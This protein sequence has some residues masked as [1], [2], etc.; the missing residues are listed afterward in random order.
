MKGPAAVALVAAVVASLAAPLFAQRF[1]DQHIDAGTLAVLPARYPQIAATGSSVYVA[2][3]ANGAIFV[4]GS[5]DRGATWKA[6]PWSVGW[7]VAF[8]PHPRLAVWGSS[9]HLAFQNFRAIYCTSSADGGTTWSTEGPLNTTSAT[10]TRPQVAASGS[11]VYVVWEDRRNRPNRADIYL[12]S[13]PDGGVTWSERRLDTDAPGTGESTEPRIVAS[14][15][16]VYVTWQDDRNAPMTDR[17][18]YFN[19]S[20]DRGATWLSQDVRLDTDPAGAADSSQ[21]EIAASDTAVYVTWADDR[22]G[23]HD[24]YLNYSA[25]RGR[26]WQSQDLR[27]NTSLA[28]A[29]YSLY[30]D[31]AV[32]G[33]SVYVAWGEN[34]SNASHAYF[35]RSLDGGA[36]WLAQQVRIDSS[37]GSCSAPRIAATPAG[38]HAAW[39]DSRNGAFGFDIY[40]NYSADQGTTWRGDVRLDTDPAGSAASTY[41]EIAVAGPSVYV[42]WMDLRNGPVEDVYFNV[43]FGNL[44]YG[45]A[46]A[47]TGGVLPQLEVSGSPTRGSSISLDVRQ[48]VGAAIGALWIGAGPASKTSL[49]LLGGTVLV[50]PALAVPIA[51]GGAAGVAGAGA[52]T[53]PLSIP[54]LPALVGANLNWQALLL[55][56]G[57]PSGVSMT[58]GVETW[59]G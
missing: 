49:P 13:S 15:S 53:L 41:P 9:V 25:D 51:L 18:V 29:A 12:A 8:R 11:S 35:N 39:V 55:D 16:S 38:V 36:T 59:I 37:S 57:A 2:W 5:S 23:L 54:M 6:T 33:S 17:D 34:S 47:G 14:G 4:N 50:Q 45:P 3:E 52:L 22:N 20:A 26:T 1:P 19:Y 43:P 48:G 56:A 24:I 28:G 58:P 44:A 46:T 21:L 10:S 42:T 31:V 27:I 40:F 30:P 7:G 32:A